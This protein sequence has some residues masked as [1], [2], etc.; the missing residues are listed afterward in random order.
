MPDHA[1]TVAARDAAFA[2]FSRRQRAGFIPAK[3]EFGDWL[4]ANNRPLFDAV[5]AME[6]A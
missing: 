6:Q 2:R 1:D 5:S 4:A 3:V